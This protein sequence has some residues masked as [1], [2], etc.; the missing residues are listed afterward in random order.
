MTD[1]IEP[2]GA[3]LLALRYRHI[4]TLYTYTEIFLA[5]GAYYP[6]RGAYY[7]LSG[8]YYPLSG[9]YYPLRGMEWETNGINSRKFFHTHFR[10]FVMP[11][12]TN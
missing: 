11:G 10:S 4:H 6:L 5:N 12:C 3:P 7:P 2:H 1:L 8:A 9:A